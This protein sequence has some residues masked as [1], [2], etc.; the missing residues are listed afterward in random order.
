M[1]ILFGIGEPFVHANLVE[2]RHY[3]DNFCEIIIE[4]RRVVHEMSFK[5]ISYLQLWRPFVQ[6][7]VQFW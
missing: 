6:Q 2:L 5:D 4:F 7:L 1:A 3:K